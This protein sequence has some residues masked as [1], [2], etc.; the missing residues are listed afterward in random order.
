[1]ESKRNRTMYVKTLGISLLAGY[2]ITLAGIFLLALCLFLF[3]VTEE[4]VN[5]GII[6][7]YVVSSL[8]AGFLAGKQIKTRKFLWG[9]LVGVLYYLILVVISMAGNQTLTVQNQELLT[10]FLMCVG[11][12]T[13]G[14]MVS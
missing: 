11:S 10:T 8:G 5:I 3:Q 1:M 6:I 7:I 13:L 4:V 14:G 2:V 9:M 12:G